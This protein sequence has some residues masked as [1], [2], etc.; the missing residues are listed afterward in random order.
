[1]IKM[2]RCSGIHVWG[3]CQVW[4]AINNLAVDPAFREKYEFN[5][6]RKDSLNSLRRYMNEL[7]FDQLPVLKDLQRTIDE[8]TLG[9]GGAASQQSHLLLEQ[10]PEMREQMLAGR[11]WQELANKQKKTV[12]GQAARDVAKQRMEDMLKVCTRLSSR[13]EKERDRQTE[14]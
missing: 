7:L 11:D 10:V 9:S 12:F 1:M 3:G 14:R 6:F 4:L 5:D 13:R 2:A 8:L